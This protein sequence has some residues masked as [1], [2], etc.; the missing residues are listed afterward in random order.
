VA[1]TA[2][3]IDWAEAQVTNE[4]AAPSDWAFEPIKT[5]EARAK[6]KVSRM[7][8]GQLYEWGVDR[9]ADMRNRCWYGRRSITARYAD[10]ALFL[11]NDIKRAKAREDGEN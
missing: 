5:R 6:A 1:D 10:S 8:S 3:L 11:K 4:L 9:K 2:E 7:S